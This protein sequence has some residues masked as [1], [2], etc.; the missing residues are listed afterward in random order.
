MKNIDTVVR[1]LNEAFAADPAA[2][3][4]LLVNRVPCNQALADHSTLQV[5][6][7]PALPETTYVVG[8]L[9]VINGIVEELT[10]DRVAARWDYST[11]PPTL[12]G[13][14]VYDEDYQGN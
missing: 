14:Q 7:D 6:Q 3:H 11:T 12:K 10:G 13:F 9:G 2:L 5:T 8:L 4:A 1:T